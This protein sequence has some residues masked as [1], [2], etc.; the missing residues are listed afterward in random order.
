MKNLTFISD[1]KLCQDIRQF[2]AGL[3]DDL[4]GV[5]GVPRSGL[6][7]A[8]RLVL[9]RNE[10]ALGCSDVPGIWLGHGPRRRNTMPDQGT[11]LLLDDTYLTGA[12]M[13]KAREYVEPQVDADHY[14]LLMGAMY[15][16]KGSPNLDLWH[17]CVS[18][19]RLFSWNWVG[20]K[21]KL[22]NALLDID[23]VL[24]FDPD[25]YDDDGPFYQ[26]AMA[27]AKPLHIPTC[28]VGGLITG[29]LERWRGITE[30]WLASK[31]VQYSE[32]IMYPADTA[33]ERRQHRS[34]AGWK[35][36]V[37]KA[38]RYQFM[39]ESSVRQSPDIASLSGKPVLCLEDEHLYA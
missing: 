5:V 25:A 9:H 37:L 1:R 21:N 22:R 23:G 30:T 8:S 20:A 12:S 15:V 10:C 7:V 11:I 27:T 4:V 39:I 18:S 29:R 31:G 34:I 13:K 35:G 16:E 17:C 32:L 19:P 33:R 38:A 36:G 26:R 2:S 6:M 3:P 24:C 28:P 14:R